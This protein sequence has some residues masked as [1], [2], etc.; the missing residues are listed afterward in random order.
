MPAPARFDDTLVAGDSFSL[1][2]TLQ[3]VNVLG[4]SATLHIRARPEQPPVI[5]CNGVV[6][7]EGLI[8]YHIPP[9]A[10]RKLDS[11]REGH[12]QFIYHAQFTDSIGDV[13]TYL[14]GYL[15]VLKDLAV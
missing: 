8:V 4:G 1:T 5:I 2:T 10:T 3:G 6:A 13:T 15:R 11:S 7:P 12:Q 14:S 9:E